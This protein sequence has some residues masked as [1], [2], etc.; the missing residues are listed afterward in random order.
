MRRAEKTEVILNLSELAAYAEKQY[1]MREQRKW[2]D[3]PGFSVLVSPWTGKWVALLMRQWDSESGTQIQRCDLKCGREHRA[4]SQAAYL[5]AP[6]RMRGENWV[7]IRMEA[8]EEPE[9]IFRMLD[10]AMEREKE[11]RPAFIVLET[12]SNVPETF[13]RATPLP[14]PGT[15]G[16]DTQSEIPEKIR[17]MK[18]LYSYGDGS[19]QQKCVNFYLQG[20]HMEHY[21][22]DAPWTGTVQRFFPTYHDLNTRQLRGYFTWRTQVR[23]GQYLPAPVAF[24]HLYLYE[25]INGIGAADAQDSLQK[26]RAFGEGYF[27]AGLGDP[28]TQRD[29]RRWMLE[30]AVVKNVPPEIARQYAPQDLLANDQLIL[31]LKKPQ[32]HS[33]ADVF[34]ALL[35]VF[36]G[37]ADASPVLKSYPEKGKRVMAQSWRHAAAADV[38]PAGNGFTSCFGKREPFPWHPLANAVY[39]ERHKKKRFV[40]DLNECR[41][42]I[43]QD[44]VWKAE[45]YDSLYFDKKRFRAFLREADRQCRIFLKLGHPLSEKPEGAWAKPF[46]RLAIEEEIAAEKEAARPQVSLDLSML[47]HIRKDALITRDSLLT[48]EEKQQ[49]EEEEGAQAP[50]NAQEPPPDEPGGGAEDG[51]SP[52]NT[53]QR[54]ILGAL[55]R[56]EAVEGLLAAMHLMP[57]IVADEIND[58]L[59]DWIGDT[60]LSCDGDNIALVADYR[61]DIQRLLGGK[62]HE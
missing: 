48:A 29:L 32:E 2:T 16:E 39:W 61:E 8:V 19:F 15:L 60:A 37:A 21:E 62:G 5:T 52:L 22:D 28:G 49:A 51:A 31:I 56:G 14:R 54:Q 35:R 3:F 53:L 1:Q 45:S 57:S 24:V 50:N 4:E 13:Y 23:K 20:K 46:V 25:L 34:S 18:R 43:C 30:A 41:R 38:F 33:D 58:A 27:G 42:Y 40:Y 59:F 11:T 26:M 10:R 6:F 44:S 7:G 9:I 55:L 12:P 17:Q 47:D 36:G